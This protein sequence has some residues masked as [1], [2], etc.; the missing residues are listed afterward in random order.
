MIPMRA[1]EDQTKIEEFLTSA[2]IGFL[3]LTDGNSPYV[4]PL[5][6]LWWDNR[7]YFHG[8]DQGKKVDLIHQNPSCCFTVSEEYGT[9]AQPVPAHTDTAYMSVM[10][11]GNAEL[12]HDPVEATE[13]LDRMLDKY[14]PGYYASPLSQ[15]HVIKYRSSRGHGVALYRMEALTLTAKENPVKTD[16]MFYP[17]RTQ[18]MDS[19]D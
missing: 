3:G 19:Q 13:A 9:I 18:R 6:Y 5:N 11:F 16:E 4:V 12:V 8:S 15:Q 1:C 14:V 10:I 17:G 7:I 2:R